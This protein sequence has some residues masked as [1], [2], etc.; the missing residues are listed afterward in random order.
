[1]TTLRWLVRCHLVPVSRSPRS[2]WLFFLM[3]LWVIP[4]L[5]RVMYVPWGF[6]L[7]WMEWLVPISP[8]CITKPTLSPHVMFYGAVWRARK[9]PSVGQLSH[10]LVKSCCGVL[11]S[12]RQDI[13]ILTWEVIRLR[14]TKLSLHSKQWWVVCW[15][16]C[17][18]CVCTR[19]LNWWHFSLA[20]THTQ[21]YTIYVCLLNII[22]LTPSLSV[23]CHIYWTV[24]THCHFPTTTYSYL[25]PNCR[26]M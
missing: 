9:Y 15:C 18:G 21:V 12:T 22:L 25:P 24:T 23:I 13:L 14:P 8:N 16:S 19:A 7:V 26:P 2:W 17:S 4:I 1:M 5:M 20:H 11:S 10:A 6:H 3:F